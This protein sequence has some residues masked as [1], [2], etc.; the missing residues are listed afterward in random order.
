MAEPHLSSANGDRPAADSPLSLEPART[1]PRFRDEPIGGKVDATLDASITEPQL[2]SPNGARPAPESLV[3]LDQ[4]KERLA[5]ALD[6]KVEQGYQIESQTD[7]AAV[8]VTRGRRRWF[9]ILGSGAGTRQST[10]I[11]EQGRATTRTL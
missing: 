10:S 7:T 4:R 5:E 9:G 11:D 8:L 2:P 1:L 3:S 6:K